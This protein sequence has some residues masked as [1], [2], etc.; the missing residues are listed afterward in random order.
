MVLQLAKTVEEKKIK[1]EDG[2][3]RKSDDVTGSPSRPTDTSDYTVTSRNAYS[4]AAS[5]KELDT[6]CSDTRRQERRS[7]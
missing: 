3:Q 1:A 6:H 2:I 4:T 7:G 5:S